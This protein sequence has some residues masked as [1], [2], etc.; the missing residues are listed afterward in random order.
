MNKIIH[1]WHGGEVLDFLCG[2]GTGPKREA[3][4]PYLLLLD[5]RRPAMDG[6]EVLEK[7][8]CDESLM[9]L[10]IIMLTTSDD[11]EDVNFCHN[12]DVAPI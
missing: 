2:R 1:F 10:P 4:T 11:P 3:H 9:K 7:I 8:K 6:K 5:I 12:T